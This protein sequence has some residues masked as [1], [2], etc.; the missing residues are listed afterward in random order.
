[1]TPEL[2][3]SRALRRAARSDLDRLDRAAEKLRRR[4]GTLRSELERI[5]SEI[6]AIEQRRRKVSELADESAPES[7][8]HADS[9]ENGRKQLRG[10]Q[11]REFA[12]TRLHQEV[13]AGRPIHYRKWFDLVAASG[14]ELSGK[15]PV[16]T[17]LTNATRSPVVRRGGSPGNYMI[18]PGQLDDLRAALSERQAELRDLLGVI[19][20]QG[21]ADEELQ[22]HRARLLSEIRRLEA[23]IAEGERS[24]TAKTDVQG[25]EAA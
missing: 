6:R 9:D 17:F 14:I 7:S 11:L 25:P 20:R 16:A 1:M 8:A 21:V 24:L 18:A 19:E 3:P 5:Q 12:A 13:G 10:A 2:R 4:H 15:D 23:L 22:A